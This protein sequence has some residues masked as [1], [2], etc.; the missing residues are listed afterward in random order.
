ML[1]PGLTWLE[2]KDPEFAQ[3][4]ERDKTEIQDFSLLWSF[5]EG[6]ILNGHANLQSIRTYVQSLDNNGR[7]ERI[8]FSE[9]LAYVRDRYFKD[10]AYSEHFQYLYV[11]RSGNPEEIHQMLQNQTDSKRILLIGCLAIIFRLRNNLFHGEKWRYQLQGQHS[12]FN[13]A[14]L[15]L[16]K[17][18]G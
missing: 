2:Q 8:N 10:G 3:L 15:L 4:P 18:M 12:N 5:F 13:H 14:N 6:T 17:L 1:S 16:I 11:E 7:L 9:Y